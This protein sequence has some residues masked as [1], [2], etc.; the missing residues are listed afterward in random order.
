MI[1][2]DRT[3]RGKQVTIGN[4]SVKAKRIAAAFT[5]TESR[6]RP[7]KALLV[8]LAPTL[9]PPVMPPNE[10]V[11]TL[12][13]PKRTKS[14]SASTFASPEWFLGGTPDSRPEMLAQSQT[15]KPVVGDG[16][17]GKADEKGRN[18]GVELSRIPH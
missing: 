5:R 11:T 15:D 12:P 16:S 7:P 2:D 14:P 13:I 1:T 18:S 8:R 9:I 3:T 4:S 17:N 10:A 6:V